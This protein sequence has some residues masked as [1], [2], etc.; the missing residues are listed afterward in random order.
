MNNSHNFAWSIISGRGSRRKR[1][2]DIVLDLRPSQ[3]G[4]AECDPDMPLC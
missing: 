1:Y 3:C 2:Q 4:T